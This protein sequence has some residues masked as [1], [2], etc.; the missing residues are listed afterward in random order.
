MGRRRIACST[1]G[2]FLVLTGMGLLIV[3][4]IWEGAMLLN[5]KT[6]AS[7]DDKNHIYYFKKPRRIEDGDEVL[8]PKECQVECNGRVRRFWERRKGK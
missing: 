8:T 2:G 6:F 4:G 1:N 5:G 3:D 7:V